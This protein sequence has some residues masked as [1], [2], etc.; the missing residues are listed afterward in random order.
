M[1]NLLAIPTAIT[2]GSLNV[3]LLDV[4]VLALLL[5]ALIV[6][7]VKGFAKQ[8]FSI[9]GW[10]A[11]VAL[12]IIFCDDIASFLNESVPAL[13]EGIYNFLNGSIGIESAITSSQTVEEIMAILKAETELPEFLHQAIAQAI[14][15]AAGDIHITEVL[16]GWAIT[17]IS[18]VAIFIVSM[19]VFGILK[20]LFNAI[21]KKI[22][23]LGA[24]DKLFGGIF[25]ILKMSIIVLLVTMLMSSILPTAFD[26]LLHPVLETGE[27]VNCVLNSALTWVMNSE[28]VAGLLD[29]ILQNF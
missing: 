2:I 3:A 27:E 24:I 25:A 14:V 20:A 26:A 13:K 23:A 28:W 17:A 15:N 6:G 12:G 4:I 8:L 10:V 16:T 18:F 22:K 1:F 29:S 19:L 21:N 11:A 5:I 9:L 7:L